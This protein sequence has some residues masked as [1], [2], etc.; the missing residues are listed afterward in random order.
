MKVV[1]VVLHERLSLRL[2]L[3]KLGV[4]R[5]ELLRGCPLAAVSQ[6][7]TQEGSA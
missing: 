2:S 7:T 6:H 4:G 3:S 1:L 5:F